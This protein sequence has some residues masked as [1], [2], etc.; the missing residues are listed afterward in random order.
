MMK[1]QQ[2]NERI[3]KEKKER[4]RKKGNQETVKGIR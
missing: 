4:E 1:R 3:D 2:N